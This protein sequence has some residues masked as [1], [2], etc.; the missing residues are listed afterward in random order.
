MALPC[1]CNHTRQ[2]AF[3]CE[4]FTDECRDQLNSEYYSVADY[5]QQRDFIVSHV[6]KLQAI[7]QVD[8]NRRKNAICSL[9]CHTVEQRSLYANVCS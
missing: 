2:K 5:S 9:G 1:Q 4:E 8:K 6:Q 7:Y 3:R